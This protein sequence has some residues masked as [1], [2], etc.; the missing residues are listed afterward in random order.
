MQIKNI[1]STVRV[2]SHHGVDH[3][4]TPGSW[5]ERPATADEAE[6]YRGIGFEVTGEPVKAEPAAKEKSK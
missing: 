3:T 4:L 5:V 6:A 1:G 2:L